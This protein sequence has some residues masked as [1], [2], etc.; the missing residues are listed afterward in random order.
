[1]DQEMGSK[2]KLT[3]PSRPDFHQAEYSTRTDLFHPSDWFAEKRKV[4]AHLTFERDRIC[5]Q[6]KIFARNFPPSEK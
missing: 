2:Q 3:V 5:K 1:M 4:E 6:R